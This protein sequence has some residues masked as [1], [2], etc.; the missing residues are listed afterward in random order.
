MK[1]NWHTL[2]ATP[3]LCYDKTRKLPYSRLKWIVIHYTACPGDTAQREA[4]A[5]HNGNTGGRYAGAHCFV[6]DTSVWKSVPLN[7]VAWAVGGNLYPD[8]KLT[9]GGRY[10]DQCTNF[11]SISIE[12][13]TTPS[14]GMTDATVKRTIAL[15]RYYMTKYHIDAD[16]VIRHFDVT[17]KSCPGPWAKKNSPEW[18]A[19]KKAISD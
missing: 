6:D 9:G 4:L 3:G 8:V 16:H 18:E 15:T 2:V 12:M 13:C 14:G 7:R 19:F 1:L 10:Y 11:N 5:F 17:G